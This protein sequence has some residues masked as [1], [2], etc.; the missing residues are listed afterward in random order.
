M[1]VVNVTPDSFSDGGAYLD[2]A[3]AIAHGHELARAGAALLD[4]GGESTRPGAAPVDAAEEMRRV[5]PVVRAL[6]ADS[7][8]PVSIDTTKAV[9]ARAALDAGAVVVNDVS[10]GLAD[11]D[12]L[13]TVADTG[14]AYIAMHTRGTPR[15]MQHN[16][17]YDDAVAEVAGELRARVESALAAGVDGRALFADPG[18]GF[19][20]NLE[21]NVALLRALPALARRVGVPLVVGT[22]RKSFL[23]R[24]LGD[25]DMGSGRDDATLATTVWSFGHGAAVVRVHDVAASRRAVELLDVMER[26]T[27]NGL[28]A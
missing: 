27:Q 9:V 19:A 5:L 11:A 18:I 28:A 4:V 8:V 22:S 12:M 15:T 3:A 16:V 20:K 13:P 2:A 10:G 17:H 26:A 21:H 1:G 24:M 23:G 7:G 14:A 6:V 25:A